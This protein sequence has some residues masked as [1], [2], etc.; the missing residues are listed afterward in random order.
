[1]AKKKR[2][3]GKK[4]QQTTTQTRGR[5]KSE[6]THPVI[7]NGGGKGKETSDLKWGSFTGLKKSYQKVTVS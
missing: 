4:I 6:K 7:G 5:M 2:E 3:T 1:M